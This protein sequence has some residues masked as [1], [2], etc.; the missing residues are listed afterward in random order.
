MALVADLDG[1]G[2]LEV[3]V[4]GLGQESLHGIGYLEGKAEVLWTLALDGRLTSNLAGVTMGDG[5]LQL[6]AGVGSS[7]LI[8]E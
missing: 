3:V 7:L 4:P 6:G 1:D 2:T 8:W 5:S